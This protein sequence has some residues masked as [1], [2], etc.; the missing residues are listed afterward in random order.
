MWWNF[1]TTKKEE[2]GFYV[3]NHAKL[4]D[5]EVQLFVARG[6]ESNK[7][8]ENAM[9]DENNNINLRN[10]TYNKLFSN[11]D[12]QLHQM[13]CNLLSLNEHI[14]RDYFLTSLVDKFWNWNQLS[15]WQAHQ[16]WLTVSHLKKIS[17]GTCGLSTHHG[18][19]HP[20]VR[21]FL[22]HELERAINSKKR[23]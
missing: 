18:V 20:M 6:I 7:D 9:E 10:G 21:S 2:F 13:L 11:D 15:T 16:N 17:N 19:W 12:D 1:L 3:E 22:Q 5:H 8:T 23:E 4:F 14:N